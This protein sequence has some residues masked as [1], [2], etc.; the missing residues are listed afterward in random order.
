MKYQGRVTHITEVTEED[1]FADNNNNDTDI[2]NITSYEDN[3]IG[4]MIN[5]NSNQ[6]SVKTAHV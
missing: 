6:S 1:Y 5:R 4:I 2:N 3:T